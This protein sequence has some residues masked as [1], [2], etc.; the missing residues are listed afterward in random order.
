MEWKAF[1]VNESDAPGTFLG[2]EGKWSVTKMHQGERGGR[3]L[4]PRQKKNGYK[5]W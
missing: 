1:V 2:G 5:R 4:N 3:N